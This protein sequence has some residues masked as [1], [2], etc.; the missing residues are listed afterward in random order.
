MG[1]T[2]GPCTN[3]APRE[4]VA[5]DPNEDTPHVMISLALED[6]QRLD[7]NAWEQWLSAFPA[8][9]KHV[10]VQGVFKSHSTLLLVSMPVM[11]WDLLPEDHATS[12]V[13]FIRSNNLAIPKNSPQPTPI[14]VSAQQGNLQT[15]RNDVESFMSRA[16]TVAATDHIFDRRAGEP[17]AL[18]RGS[19]GTMT[20]SQQPS[21]YPVAFSAPGSPHSTIPGR[22]NSQSLRPIDSSLSLN[23]V[24][25]QQPL[26]GSPSESSGISRQIILN[27]QQAMRR[28]VFGDNVPDPKRFANHVERRLEDYYQHEPLPNDA[29]SAMLASNLGIE[30][31]HLEVWFHH[32]RERD[33]VSTRFA[34][35]K[36]KDQP[37]S[38]EDT[39]RMIL[40]AA[41]FELLDMSL[42]GQI[43]MFDLRS[44]YEFDRSHIHGALN[45]RAPMSFLQ[46]APLEV[47]ER[48]FDDE[49]SRKAF[50]ARLQYKCLLFYSKGVDSPTAC[51]SAGVILHKLRENGWFG[52]CFILKGNFREFSVSFDKFI[53][54]PKAAPDARAWSTRWLEMMPSGSAEIESKQRYAQWLEDRRSEDTQQT[55]PYTPEQLAENA[56]RLES[57][58]RELEAEFREQHNDLYR[59][60][61]DLQADH[62]ARHS[63]SR[64]EM[65]QY[66]DRGLGKLRGELS[67]PLDHEPAAPISYPEASTPK[68]HTDDYYA[69]K[70]YRESQDDTEGYVEVPRACDGQPAVSHGGARSASEAGP[71]LEDMSRRGRG[72]AGGGLLNKVFRRS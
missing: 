57:Q 22:S 2:R 46:I 55:S 12:F 33:I 14:G 42:P 3:P 4:P 66:L 59:K 25:R 5:S 47:I 35:M 48:C 31:W 52:D 20:R 53:V 41:L 36:L 23:T 69:G 21:S 60:A 58:E 70:V 54:G 56:E 1:I 19:A 11:I 37:H 13:A 44:A 40:P 45:L 39:P 29:Q 67:G 32:R 18:S 38:V 26:S 50:A 62:E 64:A 27:Q 17:S 43:L 28:T 71:V 30:L 61:R 51:P 63:G 34:S 24:Q 10:K 65:V 7:I 49:D 15:S 16:T 9:A 68:M 8:L 6:D 72:G